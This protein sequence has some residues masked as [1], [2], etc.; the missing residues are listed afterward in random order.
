[1]LEWNFSNKAL[2]NSTKFSSL[3]RNKEVALF[4]KDQTHKRI[5]F[6]LS[7]RLFS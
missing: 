4:R 5:G 1:M 7:I 3:K 6:G 2:G